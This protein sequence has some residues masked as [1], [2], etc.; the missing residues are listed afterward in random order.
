MKGS[1][2]CCSHMLRS[3]PQTERE[4]LEP[5]PIQELILRVLVAGALGGLVGLDRELS[6]K[7]AGLRTHILVSLGAA[8]FTLTG[9]FGVVAGDS[10]VT[11]DPTRVAAQ[12]V[13]GIGFLG[14]GA[15]IRQG[16]TVRGLTTASGLWV[17][18]AIGTAVAL[19][20]WEGAI[21]TTAVAVASLFGLKR[22]ERKLLR[23]LKPGRVEFVID[24]AGEFQLHEV[25][26]MLHERK[27]RIDSVAMETTDE[28]TRSVTLSLRL[29]PRMGAQEVADAVRAM[30]GVSNVDWSR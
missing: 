14:A 15:I 17:T 7:A 5:L 2:T 29:P 4:G 10:T 27:C 1:A 6:D 13:T 24:A 8:L 3:R 12:V 30:D 25:T 9:A 23:Q 19:G 16:M 28:D 18:A 11:V 22:V 21:A 26:E 20:F